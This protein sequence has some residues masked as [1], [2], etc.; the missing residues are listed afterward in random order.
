MAEPFLSII[1]PVY[2][3]E[4]YLEQC[5]D[6]ILAQTFTDFEVLLID[7][8]ATDTSPAI[9]ERY[10]AKDARFRLFHKENGGHV[11][12][13]QYIFPYARGTYVTFI[14][15]DDWI[16]PSMYEKMCG[17]AKDTGADMVCCGHFAATPE[18]NI[19]NAEFCAP[20]FYDKQALETQ[21]YPHML[22]HGSFFHFGIS[23]MIWNKLFR[24]TLLEKHFFQVPP[25]TKLGED[26][27]PAY[28]C[29]LDANS[30]YFFKECFYYYRSNPASIT[31][32]TDPRWFV[33]N[34]VFFDAFDR[35]VQHP[36]LERQR[37]YYYVYLC[38]LIL[39]AAF[40][41]EQDA[42]RPFRDAF[43][44]ECNYPPIRRSFRAVRIKEITGLHNK[45]Y[46][47]CIRYRLY[48]LFCFLIRH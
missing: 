10:A 26:A 3:A 22:Y 15:N 12:A 24:R 30:V 18:K 25:S 31:H 36:C 19:E 21:I 34:H 7:D 1:I 44:A 45:F 39:P 9:C 48:R 42:G 37:S 16:D 47:L 23:P 35:V 46:T 2:N 6:S 17:A 13:R 27:L 33:E 11:V 8:G 38:L 29:L 14:D 41:T 32:H 5:L 40:R 4:D 43:L 20:G 28:S